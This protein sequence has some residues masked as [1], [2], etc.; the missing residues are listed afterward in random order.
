MKYVELHPFSGPMPLTPTY[1]K[2][3]EPGQD[4]QIYT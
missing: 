1:S 3:T 2:I 4:G